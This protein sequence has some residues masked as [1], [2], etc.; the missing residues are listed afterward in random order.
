MNIKITKSGNGPHPLNK[1]EIHEAILIKNQWTKGEGAHFLSL[2]Y[3]QDLEKE[4]Q[5]WTKSPFGNHSGS[6][7]F[8][9]QSSTD[10]KINGRKFDEKQNICLVLKGML[11]KHTR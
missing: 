4:W 10:E 5:T 6:A 7:W 3:Q 1:I 11:T 9:Q 2:E 8:K